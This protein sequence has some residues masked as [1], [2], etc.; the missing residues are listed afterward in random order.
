MAGY[1]CNSSWAAN[2]LLSL[3]AA[4]RRTLQAGLLAFSAAAC[5]PLP[6]IHTYTADAPA[7][8]PQ[9]RSDPNVVF[10]TDNQKAFLFARPI[11]EQ[12]LLS[13]RTLNTAHRR[14]A[15]DVFS[16]QLVDYV[17]DGPGA[18]AELVLHGGDLLNNSCRKEFIDG[19]KSKG[20]VTV[21]YK[22]KNPASGAIEDKATYCLKAADLAVCAGYYK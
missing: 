21:D 17:L 11:I 6:A 20:S 22:Y 19:V 14:A 1:T 16:L 5:A 4:P 12:S 7:Q 13:E 9:K 15:L 3:T 2:I 18:K 10:V 8:L